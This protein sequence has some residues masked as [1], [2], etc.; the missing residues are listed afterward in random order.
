MVKRFVTRLLLIVLLASSTTVSLFSQEQERDTPT[1]AQRLFF[2]GDFGLTAGTITDI[3]LAPLV[4]I[5]ITPRLAVAAGPEY[6]Y[7]KS[8]Y[9]KY[10]IFGAQAYGEFYMIQ[11]L[12]NLIPIGLNTGIYAHI[13]EEVLSISSKTY[14]VEKETL[15]T[16]LVGAGIS[17]PMGPRS[18][19]H[20]TLLWAI[21]GTGYEYYNNPEIKV[22]FVF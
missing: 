2:G 14:N 18:A 15:T 21:S 3:K 17:Q 6:R 1:F 7:Y 4:G 5:W 8:P 10:H 11:N 22:S 9:N 20:V 13:E 12:N 16:L 19:M